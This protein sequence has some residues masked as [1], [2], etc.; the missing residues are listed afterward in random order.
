MFSQQIDYNG[1]KV[2]QTHLAHLFQ[3]ET[4]SEFT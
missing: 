4:V 1:N 3:L 2:E